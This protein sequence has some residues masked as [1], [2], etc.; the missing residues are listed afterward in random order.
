MWF[1][2]IMCSVGMPERWA[3][4]GHKKMSPFFLKENGQ[5]KKKG[6]QKMGHQIE[7]DGISLKTKMNGLKSMVP[8]LNNTDD[9]T[10]IIIK[11][12]NP[13]LC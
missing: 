11:I 6:G 12:L 8:S 5:R 13:I 1:L 7:K 10:K 2:M 9:F 4:N 3:K